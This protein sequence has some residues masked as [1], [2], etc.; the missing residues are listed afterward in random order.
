MRGCGRDLH[1]RGYL[2]VGDRRAQASDTSRSE[3]AP[4]GQWVM[5]WPHA[6]Q[7]ASR[8]VRLSATPMLERRARADELPHADALQLLAG[9]HTAATLNAAARVA[10]DDRM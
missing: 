4:T 1:H 3:S 5:H 10:L 6:T 2:G 9:S 8:I 7:P